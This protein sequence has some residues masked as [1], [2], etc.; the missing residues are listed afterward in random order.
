MVFVLYFLDEVVVGSEMGGSSSWKRIPCGWVW[1][2]IVMSDGGR[3]M[4]LKKFL[5]L[6]R[7]FPH[8]YIG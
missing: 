5:A 6:V 8:L 7:N 2:W 4:M 3:W 1:D